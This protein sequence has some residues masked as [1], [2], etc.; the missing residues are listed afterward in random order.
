MVFEEGVPEFGIYNLG[1]GT[2]LDRHGVR[3]GEIIYENED[4]EEE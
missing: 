1:G 4:V 2:S 3:G